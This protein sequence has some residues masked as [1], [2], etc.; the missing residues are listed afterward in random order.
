M[1]P[2][3]KQRQ[4]QAWLLAARPRTLPLACASILLGSGLAATTQAF[5]PAVLLLA[6]SAGQRTG[7][8]NPGL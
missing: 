8:N 2:L 6:Y 3:A 1:E 4:R 5:N 7:G